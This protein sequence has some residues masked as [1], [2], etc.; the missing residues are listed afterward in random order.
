MPQAAAEP[1]DRD[2]RA[3]IA[4]EMQRQQ[5]VVCDEELLVGDD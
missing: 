5:F 4:D 2:A 1:G 3:A